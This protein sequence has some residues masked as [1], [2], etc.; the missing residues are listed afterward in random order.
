MS[1]LKLRHVLIGI[2]CFLAAIGLVMG[3]FLLFRDQPEPDSSLA[4]DPEPDPEPTGPPYDFDYSWTKHPYIAH[5]F[6]AI[7]GNTYTNSYEA[8]LLNYQL[9]HRVF[10]VDFDITSDGHTVL[11][12]DSDSWRERATVRV[13]PDI[14]LLNEPDTSAF[15]YANFMSSLWYNKYRPLDVEDLLRLMQ[16]YPDIYIVTDTK[17]YDKERVQFQ[18]SEIVN[19]A[20]QID[21]SLL[22]R[23]IPQIYLPEMFDYIMEVYPWRSVIYTL[24]INSANWT[25]ENVLE[26]SEESGVK[27]VT[28]WGRW[29]EKDILDL[30]HSAELKVAAHTINNLN[31]VDQLRSAGV[32]VFYTDFLRP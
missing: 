4:S 31:T 13:D 25:P 7:D 2:V 29:V 30:W 3:G 21:E 10:E 12:H 23:F 16:E 5:A 8:F 15:T 26:F 27:F 6:G 1:N 18:F 9:G 17:Y 28:M 22:E 14:N 32:N 20:L 19:T 24:Y 11:A